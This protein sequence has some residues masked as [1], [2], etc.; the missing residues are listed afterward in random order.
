[1]QDLRIPAEVQ[2]TELLHDDVVVSGDILPADDEVLELLGDATMRREILPVMVV[3]QEDDREGSDH[4]VARGGCRQSV[5]GHAHQ[6]V[7]PASH[8]AHQ[9][10]TTASL[11]RP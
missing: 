5:L 6:S 3:V 7:R 9:Y 11:D 10:G 1:M 2:G 4:E 8:A